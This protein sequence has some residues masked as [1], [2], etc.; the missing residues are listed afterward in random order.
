M[1]LTPQQVAKLNPDQRIKYEAMIRKHMS[2]ISAH[3]PSHDDLRRLRELG[4]EENTAAT[5]EPLHDIPM[6]PQERQ[7][8][9][10][11][12]QQTVNDMSKLGKAL[13]R[14]YALTRDEARA[15][16]YFKTVSGSK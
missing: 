2:T 14:W 10:M 1:Q 4:Q 16:M 5:Q 7:E 3:Q 15:R 8:M 9:L 11:K 12:L 13:G 6:T